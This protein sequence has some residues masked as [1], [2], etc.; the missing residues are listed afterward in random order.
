MIF[1][2][3][4]YFRKK[5]KAIVRHVTAAVTGENLAGGLR[6]A[7]P[8]GQALDDQHRPHGR[9]P[10][11]SQGTGGAACVPRGQRPCLSERPLPLL[12]RFL[13]HDLVTNLVS[14]VCGLNLPPHP[15]AGDRGNA[16]IRKG[17][18]CPQR[19]LAHLQLH[20]C[21]LRTLCKSS[22]L[23]PQLNP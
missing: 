4:N 8:L 3:K 19:S 17:K 23:S 21:L 22:K 12:G 10:P 7:T 11:S 15:V 18:A 20:S 6:A 14:Q 5:R 2:I 13:S 1:P 9:S 16:L